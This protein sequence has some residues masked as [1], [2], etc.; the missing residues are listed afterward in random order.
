MPSAECRNRVTINRDVGTD[1]SHNTAK[2]VGSDNRRPGWTPKIASASCCSVG[3]S[4]GAAAPS[5][6][7]VTGRRR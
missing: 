5:P 1:A 4:C 7:A 6:S 3:P 2:G